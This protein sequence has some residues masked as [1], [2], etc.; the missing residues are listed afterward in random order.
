[1]WGRH[2]GK[3]RR[4]FQWE[5]IGRTG[6]IQY[7]AKVPEVFRVGGYRFFFFSREGNEPQHIHVRHADKYAKF[8]LE[9]VELAES[10]GFLSSELRHLHKLIEEHRLS[11]IV[12]WDE[13][14]SQ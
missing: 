8:W 13:H 9:P 5:K 11:F 4:V 7:A 2:F 14:F 1:M 6:R 12:S 10:R 3:G